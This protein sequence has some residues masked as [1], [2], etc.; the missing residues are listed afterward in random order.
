MPRY[1]IDYSKIIIYKIVCKDL[2]V[3]HCYVG[4]TT[5]FTRRKSQHKRNCVNSINYKL[6]KL[7]NENGG[8][9]NFDMV[10]IETFKCEN[11]NEAYARERYWYESLNSNM[12]SY[13]PSRTDEERPKNYANYALKRKQKQLDQYD[14]TKD[15]KPQWY[16]NNLEY[17]KKLFLK[18]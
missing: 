4:S 7:I 18:V 14:L 9:E 12:N 8:W 16:L 6:Y 2:E 17:S 1:A 11:G 5:D 13:K 3:K 15:E 10:V